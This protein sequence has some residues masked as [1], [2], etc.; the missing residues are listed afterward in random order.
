MKPFIVS[1]SYC[2]IINGKLK[3][4]HVINK[5]ILDYEMPYLEY[6]YWFVK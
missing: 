4:R 5:N 3:C 2:D 6:D 1:Y